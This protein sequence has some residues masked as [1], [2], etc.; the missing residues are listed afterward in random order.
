[1]TFIINHEGICSA[2]KLLE[3]EPDGS[4]ANF[5]ARAQA[6]EYLHFHMVGLRTFAAM[7]PE[8]IAAQAC[9]DKADEIEELINTRL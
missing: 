7:K 9:L 3:S 8:G 4:G 1:M 2:I 5:A 6:A